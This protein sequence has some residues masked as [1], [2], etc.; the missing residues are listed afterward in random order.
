MAVVL[1][2]RSRHRESALNKRTRRSLDIVKQFMA[3]E[4]RSRRRGGQADHSK[5]K[6]AHLGKREELMR[7]LAKASY[8]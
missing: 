8:T 1:E 4:D 6:Q 7:T 2:G 5:L 3:A